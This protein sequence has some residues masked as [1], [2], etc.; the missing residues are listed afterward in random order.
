MAEPSEYGGRLTKLAGDSNW[1]VWKFAIRTQMREKVHCLEVI[2]GT[3]KSKMP[4]GSDSKDWIKGDMAG[5]AMITR[6]VEDK[7]LA[8]LTTS[9]TA[10]DM[11]LKL[12]EIHDRES[13]SAS[14]KLMAEYCRFVQLDGETFPEYIS[15]F[16]IMV[17]KMNVLKISPSKVML[18]QKMLCSTRGDMAAIEKSFNTKDEDKQTL[19]EL[20]RVLIAEHDRLTSPSERPIGN[21]AYAG[22]VAVTHVSES[23]GAGKGKVSGGLGKALSA[24]ENRSSKPKELG[25]RSGVRCFHCDK[26]G[27]YKRDCHQLRREREASAEARDSKAGTANTS[28][29]Y[30]HAGKES[31]GQVDRAW[32]L[33]SGASFHMCKDREAIENYREFAGSELAKISL[34]DG[35]Q[36]NGIGSGTVRTQ[37]E[38][39]GVLMD[40]SISV[41]HVPEIANNLLSVL[42]L[43]ERG[44]S[45]EF[46]GNSAKIRKDGK[47]VVRAHRCEKNLYRVNYLGAKNFAGM[48]V[49]VNGEATG[50]KASWD[51]SGAGSA[52]NWC[53]AATADKETLNRGSKTSGKLAGRKYGREFDLRGSVGNKKHLAADK[54]SSPT[55]VTWSRDGLPLTYAGECTKWPSKPKYG[56]N[57][58][59]RLGPGS[60]VTRDRSAANQNVPGTE[61]TCDV[62]DVAY[63]FGQ[64]TQTCN[65]AEPTRKL[66]RKGILLKSKKSDHPGSGYG[67]AC[68]LK[69]DSYGGNKKGNLAGISPSENWVDGKIEQLAGVRVR[70]ELPG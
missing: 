21:A 11:W 12:I 68:G 44:L 23:S 69:K 40:H 49:E 41:V 38:E 33:D 24:A 62:V 42:K 26:P 60:A 15:R 63:L 70:D 34:G 37:S 50:E 58:P 51:G 59:S 65:I 22:D 29:A 28:F 36:V 43:T 19:K 17:G 6:N 2:D 55:E 32:Y 30:M 13:A 7:V 1:L 35:R 53:L 27:H 8:Q 52:G 54:E 46:V 45:V 48:A 61:A 47:V 66:Y 4:D 3:L 67:T 39:D 20:K 14:N 16:E 25:T 31:V 9:F 10:R 57:A 64:A 18:V 5:M 56:R